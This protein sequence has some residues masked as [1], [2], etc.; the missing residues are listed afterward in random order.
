MGGTENAITLIT[1]EGAETWP[2]MTKTDV[3]RHLALRI[4]GALA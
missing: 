3:A 1:H 4:A 2:R